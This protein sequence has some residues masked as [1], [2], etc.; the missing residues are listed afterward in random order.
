MGKNTK[1]D[2]RIIFINRYFYPDHSA[3]SQILSDLAFYLSSQGFDIEIVT[4]RQ[5]YD[6]S[7]AQLV[8]A[9]VV[10]GV[11]VNRIKTTRFGRQNLLGRSIDYLSFYFSVAYYLTANLKA[12]DIVVAKTDPPMV[13]V[14]AA[15]VAKIKGAVLINWIQDL[16]PEVAQALGVKG[17]S[18]F[19]PA[20]KSLRN[21]SLRF[22]STNVV[23]GERMKDRLLHE[24]VDESKN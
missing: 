11:K 14:I 23:I 7:N 19:Y 12:I 9:D 8:G 5:K 18:L 2:R 10:N 21:F 24:G 22:A 20:I 4:S 1:K 16:F 6:D 3:T 17:L 15:I 13:S